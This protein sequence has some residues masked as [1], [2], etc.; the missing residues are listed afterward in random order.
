MTSYL[1]TNPNPNPQSQ[2]TSKNASLTPGG[3]GLYIWVGLTPLSLPGTPGGNSICP[4]AIA[5]LSPKQCQTSS[6]PR[7]VG[8]PGPRV[9]QCLR[10]ESLLE[11]MGTARGGVGAGRRKSTIARNFKFFTKKHFD[12]NY[13][14]LTRF[15]IEIRQ[16]ENKKNGISH[17]PF[18]SQKRRCFLFQL[19]SWSQIKGSTFCPLVG[20]AVNPRPDPGH[21]N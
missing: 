8:S 6:S 9:L 13:A 4:P 7:G 1:R 21:Q 12:Q 14:T 3:G 17:D 18:G 11:E 10:V 15:L 2:K 5:H 20:E 19:P 16:N